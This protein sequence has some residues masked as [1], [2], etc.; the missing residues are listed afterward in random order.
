MI[1]GDMSVFVS[2]DSQRV[3]QACGKVSPNL[4]FAK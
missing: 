4:T 3:A 1:G 2:L